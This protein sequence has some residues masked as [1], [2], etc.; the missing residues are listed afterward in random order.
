MGV[1]GQH[2][3][4]AALPPGMDT[5]L[6]VLLNNNTRAVIEVLTKPKYA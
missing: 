6:D 2:H 1:G 4:P 5:Q 3:D